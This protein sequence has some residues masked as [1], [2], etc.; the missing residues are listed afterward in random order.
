M[1]RLTS[2]LPPIT[3]VRDP[4]VAGFIT[5][6]ADLMYGCDVTVRSM[7][8]SQLNYRNATM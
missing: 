1:L 4:A 3:S 2:R 7:I 6:A 5:S 8:A